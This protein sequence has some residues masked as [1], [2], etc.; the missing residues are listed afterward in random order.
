[1]I[2]SFA[3]TNDV[4]LAGNKT[5]T[6][7]VWSDRTAR[8]W[9]NA[10]QSDR[11]IHSAWNKCSFVKG[12]KKVADIRL[13]QLPYQERLGDMP[14][15]DLDAEGGLWASKNEFINLFGSPDTVVWVVRFDL[16][17]VITPLAED[18]S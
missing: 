5:C 13:T 1:M 17:S 12:A 11:L 10:Y 18:I 16:K 4:L 14:Q 15:S 3:W 7:R 8:A 6:R 9:V 2:L